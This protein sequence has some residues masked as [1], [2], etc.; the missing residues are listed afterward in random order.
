MNPEQAVPTILEA[1]PE[2]DSI[3]G[4]LSIEEADY[5]YRAAARIAN[6]V[7][8]EVGSANGRSTIA[9][10][11]GARAGSGTAVFAIEPHE[12][13]VGVYGGQ[14]GPENRR[15]FF[16][17][18]LRFDGWENTR[19]IN[20]SSEVVGV[21]WRLPIGMLWIDGDHRYDAVRRDFEVW[22]PHLASTALIAFHDAADATGGPY[23]L[24]AECVA[25]GDFIALPAPGLIAAL[26]PA[27]AR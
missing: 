24:A 17:T 7:I 5:L 11:L 3:G 23:R 15:A 25:S 26:T 12:R 20:V 1:C 14:F 8:V 6:G 2:Y 22:R 4:W 16:E 10:S 19:L 9:L 13:F 18:M 21:G 27:P